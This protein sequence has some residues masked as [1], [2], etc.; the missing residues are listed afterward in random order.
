MPQS[1]SK[2]YLHTIFS[3]KYRQPMIQPSVEE[4]LYRLVRSLFLDQG[5]FVEEIGGT[6]DHL[7]IVHTLPRTKS[8][9]TVMEAVKSISSKGMK[10]QGLFPPNFH[11][12]DGYACFSVDPR[13]MDRL[14]LYVR[15]QKRHHY[16]DD[17][18]VLQHSFEIEYVTLLNAYDCDYSPE[19]LFPTKPE[20]TTCP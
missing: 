13:N 12:Q 15:N 11:W 9:A 18:S 2:I 7:H 3:T 4:D 19:Y 5:C 17:I 10:T 1:Y 20:S 8:I 14:V 16:G 6:A